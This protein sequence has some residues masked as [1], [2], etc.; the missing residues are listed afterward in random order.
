MNRKIILSLIL[1]LSVQMVSAQMGYRHNVIPSL[2]P[3]SVD[4][5]YYGKKRFGQSAVAVAGVNLGIWSFNRFIRTEDFAYINMNTIRDN[6][7]HGFVWDNDNLGTN[8]FF[9]PYHGNLYFNSARSNGYNFWQ[10]GLF[11]LGGSAMW[12][13]FMENEYP[14][15]NDIIATPIGGMALG[16]TLYRTSDLILDDRATGTER[17]GRE[18]ATFLVSPMRG[19]M[20]I[21][22][23]D[24]WRIRSTSG[25]QF[26]IPDL[27]VAFSIGSR[28]LEF[29]DKILDRGVGMTSEIDIEYGDRFNTENERPYDYF[30]MRVGLNVQKSQPVLGQVNLI[31]RLLN[32]V[33]VEET[34]RVLNFGLYQ[35]F[36]FY[37]SNVISDISSVVPYKIAI[38]ASVGAGLQFEQQNVG[39]W[40]FLGSMHG[41]GIMMGAVLSDHY[42]LAD[43]NY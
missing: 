34:N 30:A 6:F 38:P 37:D 2:A 43:R 28:I 40:D 32:R 20:R 31:G 35:H 17:L 22:N 11:A 16:E 27:C 25:R 15:A 12:E 13:L 39:N 9:H 8:M 24:A 19:M 7:K 36:D 23:G 3:D 33:L 26:G 10:S 14:S 4:L 42:R 1:T 5:Q 41:N 21:V 18:I 29:E